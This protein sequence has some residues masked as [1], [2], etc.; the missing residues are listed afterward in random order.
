MHPLMNTMIEIQRKLDEIGELL[1]ELAHQ[2]TDTVKETT[3]LKRK[4]F[5]AQDEDDGRC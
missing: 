1:E 4:L 5:W 3:E 2:Y